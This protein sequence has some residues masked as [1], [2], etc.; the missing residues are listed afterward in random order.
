MNAGSLCTGSSIKAQ[1]KD[2]M[3]ATL[4][5]VSLSLQTIAPDELEIV[6]NDFTILKHFGELTTEISAER[7]A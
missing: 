2:V 6:N 7:F 4:D 1:H 5:P 3:V